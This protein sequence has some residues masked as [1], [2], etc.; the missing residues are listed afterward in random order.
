MNEYRGEHKVTVG[1]REYVL[2]PTFQALAAMEAAA[3]MKLIPL[4]MAFNGR[5]VGVRE[6]V[7]VL[8]EAARAVDAELDADAF[9]DAIVADGVLNF[10][11]PALAFLSSALTGG[12]QGNA[13]AADRKKAIRSAA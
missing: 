8:T 7:G 12:Q 10:V 3:G 4:A 11:E 6:I 9:A 5:N 13:G 1:G 2:R